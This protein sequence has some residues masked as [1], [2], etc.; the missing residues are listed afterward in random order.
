[1]DVMFIYCL[2]GQIGKWNVFRN[3]LKNVL[4]YHWQCMDCPVLKMAMN[5]I[6][7]YISD[8][9]RSQNL[10]IY[11][12]FVFFFVESSIV[13]GSDL[14]W[15]HKSYIVL[16]LPQELVMKNGILGKGYIKISLSLALNLT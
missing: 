16:I 3:V 7:E 1:M 14:A 10:L 11:S 15:H 2:L 6:L 8:N 5:C 12:Y 13:L 4:S 9:L